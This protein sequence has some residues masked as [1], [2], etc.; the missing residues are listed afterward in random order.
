M[1][2]VATGTIKAIDQCWKRNAPIIKE[3]L[4]NE[5]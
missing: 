2:V 5:L 3:V 4:S 1:H